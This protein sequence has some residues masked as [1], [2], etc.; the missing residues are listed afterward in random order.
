V[1]PATSTEGKLPSTY[2]LNA[3]IANSSSNPNSAALIL[4]HRTLGGV[5]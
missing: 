3:T 4:Q 1:A 2:L 5:L